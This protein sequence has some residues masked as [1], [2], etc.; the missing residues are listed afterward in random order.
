[1]RQRWSGRGK[2]ASKRGNRMIRSRELAIRRVAAGAFM[3]WS[4]ESAA[5]S[6]WSAIALE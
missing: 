6:R 4:V 2:F 5:N 1:L 3:Y